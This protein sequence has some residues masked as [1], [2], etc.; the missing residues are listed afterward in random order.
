MLVLRLLRRL[1]RPG[2]AQRVGG[3]AAQVR[4]QARHRGRRPTAAGLYFVGPGRHHAHLPPRDP[5][6]RG[7]LR[8]ARSRSPRPRPWAATPRRRSTQYFERRD[9]LLGGG[10]THRVVE[11]LNVQTSDGYAVTADVTLL[12]SIADPVK[13]AREFGWG[14][15]YVDAFVAQ[16]LPQRRPVDPGQDE[17][18]VVLR[19]GAA[20]PG[21]RGGRRPSRRSASRSGASRSKEL[22]LR[23][24]R[25]AENYEKS[26]HDKK[27][28]VQ[29]AEK[30]RK[31]SLVNEEQAKLKQIESKGNADIT[32][33]ESEVQ[34]PRSP[35]SGP[36]PSSTPRRRGPGPTRRSTWP[37]A[38]A[39]RLKADA[40]T[41]G[42]RPLRGGARD[43]EDV[44]EHRG[45][46]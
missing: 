42:G 28:A 17:R 13:I 30:N 33:A 25:Y 31:E 23:N 21:H 20:H 41:T 12:Y 14:S 24:F 34:T 27:V 5:R 6:A 1:H 3:G 40:L 7:L 44:R 19:R 46:R 29:L 39:K 32:I 2:A 43:G 9:E 38:E 36:R 18:R 16:H 26:L 15:L 37:Q 8:P 10:T 4:L 45:R 11:A 22:L 35:R